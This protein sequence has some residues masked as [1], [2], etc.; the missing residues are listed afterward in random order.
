MGRRHCWGA[1]AEA[2]VQ[3]QASLRY[4]CDGQNGT[5]TGVSPSTSVLP[6]NI[7]PLALHTHSFIYHRGC[8]TPA[9]DSVVKKNTKKDTPAWQRVLPVW[10]PPPIP[11]FINSALHENP[12]GAVNRRDLAVWII[13]VIGNT[14]TP[15]STRGWG[16]MIMARWAKSC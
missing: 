1:T 2:R 4:I 13:E 8:I 15:R 12:P 5:G 10:A 9:I 6:F 16:G 3:P 7:I 11:L 14:V